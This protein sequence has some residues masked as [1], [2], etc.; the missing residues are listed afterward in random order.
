MSVI[1]QERTLKS[2]TAPEFAPEHFDLM[3][4]GAYLIAAEL[5]RGF[6]PR[7]YS[8]DAGTS[9]TDI[10]SA[11]MIV[12]TNR[13]Y[14]I[15]NPLA[16]EAHAT[17]AIVYVS[18]ASSVNN[19]GVWR[20]IGSEGVVSYFS[21]VVSSLS[22]VGCLA[23]ISFVHG[24]AGLTSNATEILTL[25]FNAATGNVR[26]PFA[27][28]AALAR[29]HGL[30]ALS[31]EV[32][33]FSRRAPDWDGVGGVAPSAEAREDAKAFLRILPKG[34]TLPDTAYAPG[35]GEVLFQWRRADGFAEVGFFGDQTISWFVRYVGQRSKFADEHFDRAAPTVPAELI[36][37]LAQ[38]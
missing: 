24:I 20:P 4:V 25:A 19:F 23:E 8:Q 32:D 37:A 33:G 18:S 14:H 12:D 16:W 38:F 31:T 10:S 9:T 27:A 36:E 1:L 35:D 15:Q 21:G 28:D 17:D 5:D 34:L 26:I 7:A 11:K 6:G 2:G 13:R 3:G 30:A 29:E 22:N